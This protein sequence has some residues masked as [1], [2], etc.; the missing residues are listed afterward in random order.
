MEVLKMINSIKAEK[1]S[2]KLKSRWSEESQLT[3]RIIIGILKELE[4]LNGKKLEEEKEKPGQ[5]TGMQRFRC[6][7]C[8]TSGTIE[9]WDESKEPIKKIIKDCPNCNGDGF[10]NIM[11]V[12][13]RKNTKNRKLRYDDEY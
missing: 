3:Q 9:I 11:V 8:E 5:E 12:D 1:E 4:S 6:E 2:K 10:T 7:K 13:K